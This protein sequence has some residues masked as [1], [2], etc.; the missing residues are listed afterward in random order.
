MKREFWRLLLRL[1]FHLL[2]RRRFGHLVLEE[3]AG[4]PLLVLPD[5][6]NPR[7]FRT[8]E[9]LATS[10]CATLIPAGATVLD[11]GSGS[12]VGAVFAARWV[13]RVV[14]VDINPAAVRCVRIN[15][16]LAKV[17]DRIEALHGDLFTPVAGQRFDVVLFNPPYYRGHPQDALDFAFRSIDTVE[18]FA[19][20]LPEH[21][22]P[23]GQALVVLSSD[24]DTP[25]FLRT[26][27][28]CGLAVE[29]VAERDL[30]NEALTIYR[31]RPCEQ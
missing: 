2:Q 28:D 25:A 27:R 16:L 20:G 21:L 19:A 29:V 14:A 23:G 6:F 30:I 11:M 10:L 1:R 18:R 22:S 26:F 4:Q 13:R 8:G 15:A 7:L 17:E 3:I 24:A 12:G 9:F 31:L 5:V